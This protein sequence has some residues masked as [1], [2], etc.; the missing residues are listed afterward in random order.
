MIDNTDV[1]IAGLVG[2][3]ALIVDWYVN[4]RKVKSYTRSK[5]CL[6]NFYRGYIGGFSL[7]ILERR[8]KGSWLVLTAWLTTRFT[9]N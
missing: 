3:I 4:L 5:A 6:V 8:D 2:F 1:L 9:L 7:A